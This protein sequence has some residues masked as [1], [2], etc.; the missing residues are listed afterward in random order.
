ML[1]HRVYR[2]AFLP[3]IVAFFVVAF[4]LGDR[5]APVTTRVAPDAFNAE[6]VLGAPVDPLPDSLRGLAAAYP[7]RRPLDG[8]GA[9]P[10]AD[11]IA[12]TFRV[13]RF[14][15]G[16]SVRRF[17]IEADTID[18]RATVDA[19]V[20]ERKGFVGRRIVVIAHR[21]ARGARTEAELSGTAVLLEL[22]R[23][24]ADRDVN[25]SLVLASVSG[26]SGG[27][28][29]ARAVA[30]R[31]DDV[32][33][34]VVLGDLY[35]KRVRRPWVIPWST[36]GGPAPHDL[37]RTVEAAVF[38]ETGAHP[39]TTR[40]IAQWA[41][42][43]VPITVSEQGV[44]NAAG[45]LAVLLSATGELGPEP[46][47]PTSAKRLQTF[48]RSVV[49]AVTALDGAG[50]VP[51]A[52]GETL[53]PAALEPQAG[54]IVTAG[55]MLPD[56][57]VRLLVL[58]L[59]LPALLAALDAFFRAR[60]R[61]IRAVAWLAWAA[62]WGLPFLVGWAWLRVLDATGAVQALPAP[63]P[64]GAAPLD[65]AA[66]IALGSAGLIVVL[67]LVLLRPFVN[68][69]L[70]VVGS[71][72]AGGGAAG[73]GVLLALLVLGVWLV[74]PYAASVMLPA[75]HAWLLAAVVG[76]RLR[77]AVAAAALAAGLLL[78]SVLALYYV[79]VLDLSP[80]ELARLAFDLLAGGETSVFD[81]LALS[82]FAGAACAVFAILRARRRV[83][84]TA[85]PEPVR[86]RGPGG[87]AG[88]GSL[89]GTESA[90][91]R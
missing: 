14:A 11:L 85:P 61:R 28:A 83:A 81:A 88:P 54:G 82:L 10:M 58:T 7:R 55:R 43:A 63:A 50:V 4:S 80:E 71:R 75:A 22:A 15:S 66:G 6:R 72:A 44:V 49:R 5:P 46:G 67:G 45:H 89:G 48:G 31:L 57:A 34:V 8:G 78:P 40:A 64:P 26:G 47:A 36:S 53:P 37:R 23:V 18:G 17:D 9:M 3:A 76:S 69:R 1:D 74:N 90:L 84:V 51:S 91:R 35:S 24:F 59:L 20:A 19:V 12:E 29:G 56:W 39:G 16:G 42:R 30:E 86:T 79:L 68:R 62:A 38:A 65:S 13:T 73:A 2:A 70:G 60:R 32:E 52:T 25:R 87:Y 33:A 41:R 27:Y 21:D 77:G